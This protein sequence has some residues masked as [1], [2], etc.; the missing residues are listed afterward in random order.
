MLA[1]MNSIPVSLKYVT[2]YHWFIPAHDEGMG[3]ALEIHQSIDTESFEKRIPELR[4]ICEGS[5]VLD[6]GAYTGDTTH[7]FLRMGAEAIIAFEPYFDAWSCL[8]LNCPGDNVV[9]IHG[10]VG[11]GS[12]IKLD[13]KGIDPGMRWVDLGGDQKTIRLDDL[14][15][16]PDFIKIDVEGFELYVL[17]GAIETIRKYKPWLLIEVFPDCL[18]RYN[19]SADHLREFLDKNGY[20]YRPIGEENSVRWDYLAQPK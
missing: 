20:H 5:T 17:Q 8:C 1:Q 3:K 14:N 6:V 9:K 15:P 19:H 12:V 7:T 10:A 13:G 16:M 18:K 2:D 4:E 11:D